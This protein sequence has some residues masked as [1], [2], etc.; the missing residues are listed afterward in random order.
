[1]TSPVPVIAR[2]PETSGRAISASKADCLPR[3]MRWFR[4]PFDPRRWRGKHAQEIP[5]M[6]RCDFY[7]LFPSLLGEGN[8]VFDGIGRGFFAVGCSHLP[9][10]KVAPPLSKQRHPKT[11]SLGAVRDRFTF[12]RDDRINWILLI[13]KTKNPCHC[14][15]LRHA[16]DIYHPITK[17]Y[18]QSQRDY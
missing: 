12:V 16:S 9:K 4:R 11:P 15:S 3:S 13:S 7:C 2:S 6:T 10:Q 17:F 1:M 8:S 18:T 14:G 5:A